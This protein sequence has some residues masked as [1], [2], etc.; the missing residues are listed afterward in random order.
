MSD[1]EGTA[2]F[3]LDT[4]TIHKPKSLSFLDQWAANYPSLD[5]AAIPDSHSTDGG[6]LSDSLEFAFGGDPESPIDDTTLNP[7]HQ[8][9]N[10]GVDDFLEI[11]YRR[12]VYANDRG[13]TYSVEY[14]DQ[15]RF[16]SW[17]IPDSTETQ[18]IAID[19]EFEQVTTQIP[20]NADTHKFV[21]VRI[22]FE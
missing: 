19:S 22:G 9:T 21:R 12:Q 18:I 14:S 13:I 20:I 15:L 2:Q 16:D 4:I 1:S 7:T 10:D 6:L 11:R 3:D 17:Q 8:I 5:L